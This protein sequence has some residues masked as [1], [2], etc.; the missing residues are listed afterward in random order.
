MPATWPKPRAPKRSPRLP[1][2]PAA[3]PYLK[4]VTALC[5][6]RAWPLPVSE[7]QFNPDRRW[8]FDLAWPEQYIAVEIQG[9]LFTQG[10]HTQAA[11]LRREYEKLNDAAIAGWCVLLILPEDVQG[12]QLTK[13]LGAYFARPWYPVMFH[14]EP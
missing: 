1:V 9:G 5:A 12:G 13:L 8:R 3:H 10:R 2:A 11:A 7:Y 6:D 4:L 14:V